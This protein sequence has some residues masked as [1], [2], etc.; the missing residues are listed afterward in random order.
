LMQ[1]Q[2]LVCNGCVLTKMH[3]PENTEGWWP[4]W[5]PALGV[6]VQW[7]LKNLFISVCLILNASRLLNTSPCR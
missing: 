3:N 5:A 2:W 7:R 4:Y 6:R 1:L